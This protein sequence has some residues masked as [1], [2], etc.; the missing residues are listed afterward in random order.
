MTKDKRR[1]PPI[2]HLEAAFGVAMDPD[3]LERA[4]THRS[5]AY[6]NGGLPTNERLE[7]LGDSVL[8]VVI[9]TALF[10]NHPD[11]PEGQLAKLRASVVNMRALAD[12]ARR[13]GPAGLGPYL[14]LGKG[15]ES[16][17]GRD[18]ASILADT[19]EALLGAIYLQYGLDT[20]AIVIHRL[21]DPLMAESAGRGAALDWKTSLQELTAAL[22]LGVPEY[23]IDEAGPDHAKTFTAWVVVAGRKYGGADGRSKKEAEQRAAEAAWRTLSEQQDEPTAGP[24]AVAGAGIAAD[25]A[26]GPA[27]D[28]TTL[29]ADDPGLA[30][31][32]A[33]TA[34]DPAAN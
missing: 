18:K 5:F 3:L 23:R 15:E 27:T 16:T 34:G 21:F 22:G 20:V 19:L 26:A 10:H 17:G 12:V 29:A 9:T 6:E 13:L 33:G 14:L 28:D 1:R 25:P 4:L 31:E 7:F 24:A 11:L 8:G 32:G 2:T 30:V